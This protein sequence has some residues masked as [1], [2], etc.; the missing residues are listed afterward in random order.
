VYAPHFYKTV[1]LGTTRARTGAAVIVRAAYNDSA[2]NATIR[3][4]HFCQMNVQ[5]TGMES[6]HEQFRR[7]K[8][9]GKGCWSVVV[10]RRRRFR[11]GGGVVDHGWGWH[12]FA[13]W[14]A[15]V[16]NIIFGGAH[17]VNVEVHFICRNFY[18]IAAGRIVVA[19]GTIIVALAR[20]MVIRL[21]Y[22]RTILIRNVAVVVGGSRPHYKQ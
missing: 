22:F 7:M 11:F 15:T 21:I 1:S 20:P 17:G 5:H 2:R 12:W 13:V 16:R 6:G 10:R 4:E 19:T 9:A 18:H 8:R 14:V 3:R